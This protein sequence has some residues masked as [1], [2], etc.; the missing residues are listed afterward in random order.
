MKKNIVFYCH[1]FW[2]LWH[3]RR[4]SLIIKEILK[5]FWDF[6]NVIFIN[7][8]TIQDFL[9]DGIQWVKII[10]LPNYDIINYKIF[11][12]KKILNFRINLYNKLFSIWNIESLIVE[13]FPFWRNF[14]DNE[15]ISLIK[16][17]KQYNNRWNV[18]SSVRDIFEID[19]INSKN[20]EFIDRF[21]IHSDKKIKNYN[22]C[23]NSTI[24]KKIIYTWYVLDSEKIQ[25]LK[26]NDSIFITLWW[27]QDWIEYVL[28]FL[29]KYKKL[30]LENIIYINLWL[31]YNDINIWLINNLN[32]K[33]IVIKDYFTNF[34]EFKNKAKLVVS[35]WWYNSFIE[36]IYYNKN[37]II[38]PRETD[39]EQTE[40]LKIFINKFDNIFDWRYINEKDIFNIL[41]WK[42]KYHNKKTFDYN[43]AY[44][45][46]SFITNFNKYKYI[47]IR[48]TNV[49][50]AKCDM[51]WVIK[52]KDDYNSLYKLKE[53]ILDFYKLWWEVV[54]FTWWEPTVYKWF[55]DLLYLT[56]SLWLITS[57][58][59]NGST[60]WNIFFEKLYKNGIRLI[61]Y[62][63]I[64]IDWLNEL[65]DIRRQ[66]KWLFEKIDINLD[67]F[68]IHWIYVHINVTIRN[69][70]ILEMKEIFDYLKEKNIDSISFWMVASDPLNDTSHLIPNSKDIIEF[71]TNVKEYILK[72]SWKIKIKFSPDYY[73]SDIDIF[74]NSIQNKN[75]FK[76]IDWNKCSFISEKNEIRINEWWV[77]TP[78]CILDDYDEWLWNINNN[79][80][81]NIVLSKNYENFLNKTFPNISKACLNCKIEI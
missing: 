22:D 12:W 28:D 54:N 11:N 75:A 27:W 49:C 1:N 37:S 19:S 78:C 45:S 2:W 29:S 81:L 59:T 68:K 13:H 6:Y 43:W 79:N 38:Y 62:I 39:N 65:Q 42:I 73:W 20:L 67:N 51:C 18:F 26:M 8:W 72:N 74:I 50:N 25:N 31:N 34:I 32:I 30:N 36:N 76:K 10:N 35:M 17:Y 23:F 21:L 77:I 66:H 71:Y 53:S 9:F 63:D 40:R 5:N 60:L 47:K 57:V 15:I 3:T 4:I 24:S 61:D 16:I 46:A 44:F 64:S 14:L 69:D 33:N 48:V 41:S 56:K 80:L 7:S 55:W 52:R 70:N 58:S